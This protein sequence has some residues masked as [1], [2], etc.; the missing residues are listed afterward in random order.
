M[1]IAG[2]LVVAV[3]NGAGQV[4]HVLDGVGLEEVL[5]V[6]VVKEDAQAALGIINLGLEGARGPTLDPLHVS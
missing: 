1:D 6:E 3:L 4:G 5:V 2:R